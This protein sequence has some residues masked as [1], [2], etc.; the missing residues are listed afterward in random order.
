MNKKSLILRCVCLVFVVCAWSFGD[1]N[2]FINR[3]WTIMVMSVVSKRS[4][5]QRA[6]FSGRRRETT[7]RQDRQLRLLALRDILSSIW[8]IAYQRFEGHGEMLGMCAVCRH[9]NQ[10]ST[11][12]WHSFLSPTPFENR[13]MYLSRSRVSREVFQ[14][15]FRSAS[16]FFAK[17]RLSSYNKYPSILISPT[18]E[19]ESQ[20]DFCSVRLPSLFLQI[21]FG[22][23]F[24]DRADSWMVKRHSVIL[25]R[26][27]ISA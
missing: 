21:R 22:F 6:K 19:L 8:T 11:K 26:M 24:N 17:I 5:W 20:D 3:D 7:E 18:S 25:L 14:F 27:S 13:M 9:T 2:P 15:K 10:I 1:E 16:I 23:E 12:F 4:R